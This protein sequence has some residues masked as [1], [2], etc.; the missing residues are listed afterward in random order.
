MA[1]RQGE[2]SDGGEGGAGGGQR[3]FG[4]DVVWNMGG[5]AALALSGVLVNLVIGRFYGPAV[6]GVFN[7]VLAFYI[8]AAQFAV[9][10]VHFSVLRRVSVLSAAAGTEAR[11]EIAAEVGSA[12]VAV[13]G[14]ASFV[15]LAGFLF[16]PAIGLIVGSDDVMTGWL[17]VLPGLWLYSV[18]KVLLNTV[19]GLHHMR[20]FAIFQSSRFLL[21]LAFVF[22][23]MAMDYSG[24]SIAASISL[25]EVV[26]SVGL[27]GYLGRHVALRAVLEFE[28][29]RTH[30][31]FGFRSAL[32]GSLSELNTRV[33]VLVLGIFLSDTAVGIYSIAALVM[34]GI[35][36]LPIVVRNVLNPTIA[37]L[38]EAGR[39]AELEVEIRKIARLTYG[40]VAV[41]ALIACL[42]FPF[43]V[44]IVLG[45]PRYLDGLP[46]AIILALGIVAAAGYLPLDMLLVQGNRPG[47]QT[48][49]KALVVLSNLVLNFALV[50][51]L[52][53]EGAA[54]GTAGA[55]V[56]YVVWMKILARRTL[57]LTV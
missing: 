13:A 22:L 6:L 36:Q 50:P 51:F 44:E 48:I 4:R 42:V 54:L 32:S 12:L 25:G 39:Q 56:L 15:V 1:D 41:A 24:P 19:N 16:T 14:V 9:F 7:Q 5:F 47:T 26:L 38:L 20:A 30:L 35:S 55:Y 17:F 29:I 3:S 49:F 31:V 40:G 11:Q 21:V 52:G 8:L 57:G 33:D 28:R 46:S 37:R 10:G 2:S 45:N 18:N 23:W 43:F 27:A 53:M 34:E